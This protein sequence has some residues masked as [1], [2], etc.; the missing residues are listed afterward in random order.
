MRFSTI[1]T[2]L[3]FPYIAHEQRAIE[4]FQRT[5]CPALAICM[6][7]ATN[8]VLS[9]H[10]CCY[11]Y[12]TFCSFPDNVCT[13]VFHTFLLSVASHCLLQ[14]L[15]SAHVCTPAL[16]YWCIVL[17]AFLWPGA[18]CYIFYRIFLNACVFSL[19][20]TSWRI[21]LKIA[22]ISWKCEVY[23]TNKFFSFKTY[24]FVKTASF[25][26][27]LNPNKSQLLFDCQLVS[28]F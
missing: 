22:E 7:T 21:I 28:L 14:S 8:F 19:H 4:W 16:T 26:Q 6:S 13:L 15:L 3:F 1:F 10:V 24:I 18:W 12:A 9:V 27:H 17:S 20:E 23:K 5:M 11:V 2:A 25:L